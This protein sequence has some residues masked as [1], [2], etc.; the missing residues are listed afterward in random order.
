MSDYAVSKAGRGDLVTHALGSCLGIV[1]IDP[2]A[3]WTGLAHCMLPLSSIDAELAEMRPC[4][5]VD[6]GLQRLIAD[7]T[8]QGA[9]PE[10]LVLT[11]VG[12]ANLLDNG[13]AV[14]IGPRNLAVADKVAQHS[15]L[16][17]I[18]RAVGGHH[19]RNLS[20]LVTDREVIVKCA[21]Q[22]QVILRWTSEGVEATS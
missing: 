11:F 4:M 5:F 12:G 2:V 6:T 10:R 9:S 17:V 14:R 1:A 3:G 21:G 16:P 13:D 8:L 22:R 19:G 15:K 20:V 7:L 18:A